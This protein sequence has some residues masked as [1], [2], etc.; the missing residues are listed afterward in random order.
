MSA[1]RALCCVVA[2]LESLAF[3]FMT[4]GWSQLAGF[5]FCGLPGVL[6]T[7]VS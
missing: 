1:N 2:Q 7:M 5:C 4:R 3:A 6:S